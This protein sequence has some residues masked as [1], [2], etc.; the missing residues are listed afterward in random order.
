MEIAAVPPKEGIHAE[1]FPAPPA[2]ATWIS[3]GVGAT[4]LA[5]LIVLAAVIEASEGKPAEGTR[6]LIVALICLAAAIFS[7]GVGGMY[8]MLTHGYPPSCRSAG[9]GFGIF[10][11]RIGAILSSAFGGYLLDLGKGSV[12][13]YFG[14]LGAGAV[15]L[16]VGIMINDRHVPPAAKKARRVVLDDSEV[17]DAA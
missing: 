16:M 6:T 3:S 13:P 1:C 2:T 7:A 9:I 10:M 17:D 4:L 8:A 12:V 15:L 5:N 14:T 11:G